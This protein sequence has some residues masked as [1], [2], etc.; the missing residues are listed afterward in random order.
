MSEPQT[1]KQTNKQTKKLV[2]WYYSPFVV[3]GAVD[4]KVDQIGK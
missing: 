3:V 4:E 2:K 1:N